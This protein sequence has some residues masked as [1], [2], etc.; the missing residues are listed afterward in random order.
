MRALQA[1][2]ALNIWPLF[3]FVAMWHDLEL[4]MLAWGL[5]MPAAFLPEL[6]GL[7]PCDA[8]VALR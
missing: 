2:R 5:L 4:R 7:G 3:I 8:I 6:V 1:W